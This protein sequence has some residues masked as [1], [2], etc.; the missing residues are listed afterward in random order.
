MKD[1]DSAGSIGTEGDSGSNEE[2]VNDLLEYATGCAM[3][4]MRTSGKLQPTFLIAAGDGALLVLPAAMD[5]EDEKEH[6][7]KI[8]RLICV[9]NR[10]RAVVLVAEGWMSNRDFARPS[11]DPKRKE[12]V[13]LT[14]EGH[15]CRKHN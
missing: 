15:G 7:A 6:S 12:A 9:A 1:F 10:A 14:G 5:N 13:L 8:A 11:A 3:S 2:S 4:L